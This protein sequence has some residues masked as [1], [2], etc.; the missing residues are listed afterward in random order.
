[1][2]PPA[3]PEPFYAAGEFRHSLDE[4]NRLA[5][6]APWR[7][8]GGGEGVEFYVLP[9]ADGCLW[10]YPPAEFRAVTARANANPALS[11]DARRAFVRQFNSRARSLTLD[12]QGRLVLP[13]EMVASAGLKDTAQVVL[14]GNGERFEI[15]AA[16]RWAAK[17][18]EESHDFQR[19]SDVLGL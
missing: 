8:A 19:A 3:Q 5:V 15:W 2:P 17:S 6:P 11:A 7:G 13:A 10:G 12:K 9:S 4:K 18:V 16:E 14:I 1:M